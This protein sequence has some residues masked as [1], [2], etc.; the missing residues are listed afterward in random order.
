[1]LATDLA[2]YLVDR[3]VPFRQAHTIAGQAVRRAA[4]LNLP[5][6]LLSL[7]E[8]KSIHPGF[9][10]NVAE[11]FDFSASI[12]RRSVSGGTSPQA[13]RTQLNQARQW[14]ERN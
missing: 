4:D 10:A 11:V 12:G 6:N 5:L 3:G 1:M 8:L 7:A 14:L 13:V 9:E 2:D